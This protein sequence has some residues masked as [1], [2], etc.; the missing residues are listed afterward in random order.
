M[1][2]DVR[3]RWEYVLREIK[4]KGFDLR[5]PEI[6]LSEEESIVARSEEL[7]YLELKYKD[8]RA[9]IVDIASDE[10]RVRIV[11]GKVPLSGPSTLEECYRLAG[12]VDIYVWNV[13]TLSQREFK[14][15]FKRIRRVA[16]RVG[17]IAIEIPPEGW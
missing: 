13:Y 4:A 11:H 12:T 6:K 1:R 2:L 3:D 16:R 9:F 14:N 7:K 8:Y 17:F 5:T 10:L 15:I